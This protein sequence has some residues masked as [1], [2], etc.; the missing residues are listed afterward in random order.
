MF[1]FFFVF[2]ATYFCC[3]LLLSSCSA[4]WLFIIDQWMGLSKQISDKLMNVST[5]TSDFLLATLSL[6]QQQDTLR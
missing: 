4:G 1:C 2:L 5:M 6:L 3:P